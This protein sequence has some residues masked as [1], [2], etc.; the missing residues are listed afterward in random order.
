[1]THKFHRPHKNSGHS[2]PTETNQNIE[3]IRKYG[4]EYIRSKIHGPDTGLWI[5]DTGGRMWLP[6]KVPPV[7]SPISYTYTYIVRVWASP[8]AVNCMGAFPLCFV[9]SVFG[10][11]HDVIKILEYLC[12][13]SL[14]THTVKSCYSL[15]TNPQFQSRSRL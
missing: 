1:M 3:Y 14:I 15:T 13:K 8:P 12:P 5:P 10:S 7:Y 9:P 11:M 6:G 2:L 4:N